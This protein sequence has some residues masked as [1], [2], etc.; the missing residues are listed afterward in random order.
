MTVTT[1]IQAN[2]TV[3]MQSNRTQALGDPTATAISQQQSLGNVSNAWNA[4]TTPNGLDSWSGNVSV[5]TTIDLTNLSQSG[6]ATALN[7]TGNKLRAIQI[8]APTGNAGAV[9]VA[10]G[11]SNGYSSLG[12]ISA[13]SPGDMAVKTT[14][15]ATAVSS[16]NKTVTVSGSGSDSVNILMIFGN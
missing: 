16:S 5:G 12:T 1:S 13:L 8:T 4:N 6:L 15:Q 2:L 10:P 3:N 9:Q 14:T 7:E 11:G